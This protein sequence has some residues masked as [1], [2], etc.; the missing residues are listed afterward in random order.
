MKTIV[1]TLKHA[2]TESVNDITFGK[3]I[4]LAVGKKLNDSNFSKAF[5]QF[6]E[7]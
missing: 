2:F 3:L 4:E 1:E 6:Q 5:D 7:N